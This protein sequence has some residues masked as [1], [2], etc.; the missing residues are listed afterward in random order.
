MRI[1]RVFGV[2]DLCM[3]MQVGADGVGGGPLGL[4]VGSGL[5]SAKVW[6]DGAVMRIFKGGSCIV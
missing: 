1:L 3:L 4:M 2:D 5:V 6:V